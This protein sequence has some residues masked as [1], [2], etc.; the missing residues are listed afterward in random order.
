MIDPIDGTKAFIC[1][2]P[3]FG[4]LVALTRGGRPVLGVLDQCVT[5]ERWV[6]GRGRGT[7][8]NGARASTRRCESIAQARLCASSP[9]Y[10]RGRDLTR[11]ER[12]RERAGIA[13]YGTSCYGYG[14]LASGHIDVVM[15]AGLEVYDYLAQVTIVE[16]AGGI[17]TD[18]EGRSLDLGLGASRVLAA[19]DRRVHE[20]A[21]ALIGG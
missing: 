16:E 2:I 19:G 20:Q 15:D 1:G 13:R 8:L 3:M 10:F 6:G 18:W 5:G 11:F 12:V 7:T 4:T 21:L 17:M 14:L 9:D